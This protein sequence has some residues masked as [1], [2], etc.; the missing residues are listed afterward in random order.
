MTK[1]KKI[2]LSILTIP[3]LLYLMNHLVA[4]VYSVRY[5][6][7]DDKTTYRNTVIEE[8]KVNGKLLDQTAYSDRIDSGFYD[9]LV[10]ESYMGYVY[11]DTLSSNFNIQVQQ[12]NTIRQ[13][14]FDQSGQF[15]ASKIA[16]RQSDSIPHNVLLENETPFSHPWFDSEELSI[17]LFQRGMMHLGCL[18]PFRGFGGPN[19]GSNCYFWT[20]KMYYLLDFYGEKLRFKLPGRLMNI[21]LNEGTNYATELSYYKLPGEYGKGRH[22]G[23]FVFNDEEEQELHLY[24][25]RMI[26]K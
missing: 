11:L 2:F 4:M 6:S 12:E 17:S 20:G 21:M 8:I 1:R 7:L 13:F 23:F 10:Y 26:A 24:M 25:I 18:N 5:Q 22:I 16:N 3:V 19:G 9:T 14:T 15:I